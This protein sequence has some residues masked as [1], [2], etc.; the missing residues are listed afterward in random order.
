MSAMALNDNSALP[1]SSV[2]PTA[3]PRQTSK[4]RLWTGRVLTALTGL[5]LLFDAVGKLVM[6]APVVEAFHRLDFPTSL[7]VGI[8]VLLLVCTALYLIPR[9]A[10]LGA[11]LLSAFLGGAVAIQMRA[12][13]PTFETIFPVLFAI[14][15]WAGVYLRECRLAALLP[16]RR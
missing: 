5:F 1:L 4:A 14:L 7:G 2:Q 3:Q 13:S 8:G 12:G 15:A 6:P 11:I 10:V 16:L 9:T